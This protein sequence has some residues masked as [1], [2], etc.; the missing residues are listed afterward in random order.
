MRKFARLLLN[1]I[2]NEPVMLLAFLTI[3]GQALQKTIDG[4]H[5]TF[6]LWMTY[7]FQM[8]MASIARELVSPSSKVKEAYMRGLATP[9]A[10]P[11]RGEEVD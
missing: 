8:V 7:L 10:T 1:K 9:H 6:T 4:G 5:F 3:A 11:V 2:K